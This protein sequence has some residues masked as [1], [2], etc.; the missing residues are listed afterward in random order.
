MSANQDLLDSEV[1]RQIFLQRHSTMLVGEERRRIEQLAAELELAI[2]K[3]PE[4][5]PLWEYGPLL[6]E[7]EEILARYE[8][9]L[10]DSMTGTVESVAE[11]E[12][13]FQ[14]RLLDSLTGVGP[15]VAAITAQSVLTALLFLP[16]ARGIRAYTPEQLIQHYIRRKSEDINK[17]I[18]AGLARG[19]STTQIA[20]LVRRQMDG[21]G[22]DQYSAVTKTIITHTADV[23]RRGV[24]L[25]NR[26][27]FSGEEW[28]SVLDEHTTAICRGRD[29]DIYP[30]DSGP[31]PPAHYGCRS[32]RVPL[33]KN[34]KSRKGETY[35]QWL[36]RQPEK[37]QDEVLGK[38][39]A[40]LFRDGGLELKSFVDELGREYTLDELE[41]LNP[42][43]FERASITQ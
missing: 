40:K 5:F 28:V 41:A 14:Q 10:I 19:L 32:L 33:L 34:G 2:K 20:A 30:I 22:T 36:K 24:V 6:R 16:S 23:A 42:L 12:V 25:A 18:S 9:S 26:N 4:E 8:I 39:K 21:I 17:I 3:R 38:T 35:R 15:V 7:L 37:V 31:R 27:L 29:G 13:S 43:A 1:R 11:S